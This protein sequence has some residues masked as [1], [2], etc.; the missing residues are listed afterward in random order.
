MGI[1]V[2]PT[3]NDFKVSFI[4]SNKNGNNIPLKV[5]IGPITYISIIQ[6]PYLEEETKIA[7]LQNLYEEKQELRRGQRCGNFRIISLEQLREESGIEFASNDP[8]P[9]ELECLRNRANALL[10]AINKCLTDNERE[11]IMHKYYGDESFTIVEI[12]DMLCLLERHERRLHRQALE[13]LKNFLIGNFL[14]YS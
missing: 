3:I 1:K 11:F 5:W 9:S 6:N 8:T 4:G 7:Y 13:K 12:A 10:E 2:E 14:K